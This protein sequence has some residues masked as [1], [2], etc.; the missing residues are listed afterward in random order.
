MMQPGR[1]VGILGG[2]QLGRMLALAAARLGLNC[3]IYAP[4]SDSPAFQVSAART[5]AAYADDAALR[6]FAA[7]VDVVTFEF[8]NVPVETV[9]FLETLVPVRPGSKALGVAQDR[10][11]EKQLARGLGAMTADFGSVNS[12][13]DLDARLAEIG[14]PAVLKTTRFGY[15]GKGQVKIMSAAD[16]DLAYA[17][18]KGQP[19][20]LEGF[21][22]F[23]SEVSVVAARGLD[24]A[25]R[26]FDVTEN[27][28]R[29]HILHRSVAPAPLTR[30]LSAQAVAIT[31]SIADALEY[32]GV[33]G[34][35]FFVVP[36]PRSAAVYVNEIAP[37]VHNSG[38]W[39]MDGSETDQFEQHIRAICGWP[40][41]STRRLAPA[42]EM[43]NLIGDDVAGWSKLLT[44]DG[45]H[46]HLYGKAEARPGRKMGHVN[47]LLKTAPATKR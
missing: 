32:V 3:H 9:R 17:A 20:I 42:A 43:I 40:L 13:G 18:M 24:G 6:A 41:G 8:E 39:T 45:S 29:N 7:S 26:A 23:S 14:L 36:G 19:A 27:E 10:I 25:F 44:R 11:R 30:S 16:A 37:R 22:R 46:L 1:I 47:R 35:E 2:G 34:V 5:V 21:V 28:H 33:L 12:R 31:R 4:E 15:D 38:H